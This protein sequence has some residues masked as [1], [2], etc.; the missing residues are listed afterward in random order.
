VAFKRGFLNGKIRETTI[1]LEE[2]RDFT[3][4]L[5]LSPYEKPIELPNIL[6]D[7]AKWDLRPESMVA[8]DELVETLEDNPNI[9]IELMSHTDVRPFSVMS[10]LELSQ[11]RAQSV[12]DY[13]ISKGIAADRLKARGYGPD[14]PRVVDQ[15]IAS[16]YNF[17][18]V[19]DT[20]AK[21][22]IDALPNDQDREI[23]H[24]LNR[25]TEFS[26]LSTNYVPKELRTGD[27]DAQQQI[28]IKGMEELQEGQ[29]KRMERDRKIN[30]VLNKEKEA[31]KT[32][33]GKLP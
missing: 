32:G 2:S 19:G 15:K 33:A 27:Y 6:Y 4:N 30:P 8:L 3:T 9:T 11:N 29:K 21:T 20:L 28:L 23:A 14:V 7:L 31:S 25:R 26:V 18:K 13:L 12:V 1:G 16:Q 22:F 10:N 17:L 5:V 24:Q